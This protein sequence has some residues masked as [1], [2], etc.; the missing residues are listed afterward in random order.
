ML[1]A[2]RARSPPLS[3]SC[4]TRLATM[5]KYGLGKIS[6]IIA[7]VSERPV[8]LS[9]RNSAISCVKNLTSAHSLGVA[10]S[11]VK[12]PAVS[13]MFIAILKRL[14]FGAALLNRRYRI[15][16]RVSPRQCAA[17]IAK[18]QT[19]RTILAF[20]GFALLHRCVFGFTATARI[21]RD[22]ENPAACGGNRPPARTPFRAGSGRCLIR[23]CG[24]SIT[25]T[26]ARSTDLIVPRW[27]VTV[28][29]CGR[30]ADK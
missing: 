18:T 13:R 10:A 9:S 7:C 19:D 6:P 15:E 26:D 5:F 3:S 8:A 23:C 4:R 20:F 21:V 24:I 1:Y 14:S 30:A 2:R 25:T 11:G 16:I 12:D 29:Q 17:L 27:A 28:C 22:T